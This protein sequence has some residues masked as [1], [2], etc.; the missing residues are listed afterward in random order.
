M[1]AIIFN[2]VSGRGKA[3]SLAGMIVQELE[4]RGETTR[5][6]P[7]K[8]QGDGTNEAQLALSD[9]ASDFVCIGGDGTLSEVVS[10]VAG[11][12]AMLYIVPTGTGNDFARVLGLPKEP[13]KAFMAQLDGEA[14][15][16]DCGMINGRP[17]LN[18]AGSGFDVEVLR[19]MEELKATYPGPKAYR[20]AVFATLGQFTAFHAEIS[21]DDGPF[22]SVK[23]TII[24][25]AN[26]QYIGG[27]MRVAPGAKPDDGLFS[28]VIVNK[29]PRWSVPFLLPLFIGGLHV[30]LPV[31]RVQSAKKV[32]MRS[33]NMVVEVDGQLAQMDEARFEIMEGAIRVKRLKN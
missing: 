33:K 31:A 17:F 13:M 12:G 5:L 16:L 4:K 28:L 6:Y 9:G 19:R 14:A 3:E 30:H 20:K 10:A 22:E 15:A 21:V 32:V 7:T 11:S 25:I 26:G 2:P 18:V 23:T 24:E 1:F 8:A 29:V 27:G